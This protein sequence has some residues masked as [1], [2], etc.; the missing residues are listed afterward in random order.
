MK[1]SIKTILLVVLCST[2]SAMTAVGLYERYKIGGVH[3]QGRAAVA[4]FDQ[5]GLRRVAYASTSTPDDFADIAEQS[6]NGVVNIRAEGQIPQQQQFGGMDPFEFFFGFGPRSGGRQMQARP[7]ISIGSGVIISKDGYIITNNHV[8]DKT[9]KLTISTNDNREFIAKIVGTDPRSDLA[10]LKIDAD[11]LVPIPFGDSDALRVGE[12]VLAIGNPFNL[13]S[14]VTAGIVSAK[15]RSWMSEGEDKIASFIQTDAAINP[16]NSGGALVNTRGELIGIN[17]MIYSQTG[18][19]AGYAFAIPISIVSKVVQDL[20]QYGAVQRAV[21]GVRGGNI[22]SDAT[23]EFGLKVSEGA[24]IADVPADSPGA[25][26]GIQKGDVIVK[27][28]GT[29]IRNFAE[30]QEQLSKYR[31]G[32]KVALSINRKGEEIL[33]NVELKNIEGTTE[34]LSANDTNGILGAELQPVPVEVRKSLGI[35][36]GVMIANVGNGRLSD[37]GIPRGFVIL[38]INNEKMASVNDVR[39]IVRKV[40]Q[41]SGDKVLF[42]KGVLPNGRISYVAVPLTD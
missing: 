31:P 11:N 23:K 8:V 32:D 12:W 4:Q 15:G 9:S 3:G 33:V 22:S 5:S 35:D 39:N 41:A 36:Y 6:L 40:E 17:T 29:S 27:V 28:Q 18:S 16:G 34:V 21:L 7:S 24:L 13:S 38:T 37:A 30:L 20:K 19:Y 2:L 25:K 42:V 10:L 14:T 1:S 26:G